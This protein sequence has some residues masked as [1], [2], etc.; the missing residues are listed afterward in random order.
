[1][2]WSGDPIKLF[3]SYSHLDERFR[4]A[5]G[6]HLA[7]LL[8]D[9]L[10]EVWH[11]RKIEPGTL[12]NSRISEELSAA[13]I[14]LAL[15]SA[16]FLASGYCMGIEM[17]HALD[18]HDNGDAVVIP[19]L[20]RPADWRDTDLGK[21]QSLPRDD[22]FITKWKNRD[23]AFLEVVLGI[24]EKVTHLK[25]A[26]GHSPL[27]D[28]TQGYTGNAAD[29]KPEELFSAEVQIWRPGAEPLAWRET[30]CF[31]DRGEY[32]FRE[33]KWLALEKESATGDD[34]FLCLRGNAFIERTDRRWLEDLLNLAARRVPNARIFLVGGDDIEG[35]EEK[36]VDAAGSLY[37]WLLAAI[38]LGVSDL[39]QLQIEKSDE[40]S[41]NGLLK[42]AVERSAA[43]A[44]ILSQML[45][46]EWK[47]NI[48][49]AGR[50]L[51]KINA[52]KEE[53]QHARG[54]LTVVQRADETVQLRQVK[55][56]LEDY[57]QARHVVA[58]F[59][60]GSDKLSGIDGLT[61]SPFRGALELLFFLARLNMLR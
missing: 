44:G 26:K 61:I 40:A 12:W 34:V 16:D 11:D 45:G 14:V 8:Q 41:R 15:I 23:Q 3:I 58:L 47:C 25:K 53:L 36:I 57:S 18:R 13:E 22:R 38:E 29:R 54:I 7:S 60:Q 55:E 33:D 48:P 59:G 39:L 37:K 20:L 43:R 52:P 1:M 10:I 32:L 31:D 9:Q 21:L 56:A 17:K 6:K 2:V 19:V 24:R 46:V 27:H 35:L 51:Q 30:E 28:Q 49:H 50:L 42:V 5:L 4:I